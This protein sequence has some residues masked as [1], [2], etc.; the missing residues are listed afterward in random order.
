MYRKAIYQGTGTVY[1]KQDLISRGAPKF[2]FRPNLRP[3]RIMSEIYVGLLKCILK[4]FEI[5]D[6][7]SLNKLTIRLTEWRNNRPTNRK[8]TY[9][10]S[11]YWAKEVPYSML[12]FV[13]DLFYGWW[14]FG[15]VTV[16]NDI[17]QVN[18]QAFGTSLRS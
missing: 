4:Y 12:V 3:S 5:F 11:C 15:S 1:F 9:R 10:W 2:A 18:R 7:I 16:H 17:W 8:G 13:L 6:I 14:I